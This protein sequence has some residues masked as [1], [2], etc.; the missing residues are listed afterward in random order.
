MVQRSTLEQ[1]AISGAL[2]PPKRAPPGLDISENDQVDVSSSLAG[3]HFELS[4][5][6]GSGNK[7]AHEQPYQR[8]FFGAAISRE[9]L[10]VPRPPKV[11]PQKSPD[12]VRSIH[13]R[14]AQAT[15]G[16]GE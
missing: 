1:S 15:C 6:L 11:T 16:L 5:L 3:S 13:R 4:P 14:I 9:R 10:C 8:R 12:S 2:V 7:A